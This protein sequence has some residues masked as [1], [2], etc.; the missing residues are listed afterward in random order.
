MSENKISFIREIQVLMGY[1]LAEEEEIKRTFE[2]I[3]ATITI[4]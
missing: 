4:E 3:G 1:G 2:A